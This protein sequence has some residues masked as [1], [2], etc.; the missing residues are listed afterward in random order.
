VIFEVKPMNDFPL[1]LNWLFQ[2]RIEDSE[3]FYES[4]IYFAIPLGLFKDNPLMGRDKPLQLALY[5]KP[6]T[7]EITLNLWHTEKGIDLAA[8]QVK[9]GQATFALA[10]YSSFVQEVY[11][12]AL[13]AKEHWFRE[14]QKPEDDD[15]F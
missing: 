6:D 4:E 7:K 1:W 9:E 3:S 14:E 8:D 12:L 10:S 15:L 2:C 11:S 5:Y 13:L